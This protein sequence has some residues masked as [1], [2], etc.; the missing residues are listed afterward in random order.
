M[1]IIKHPE[2]LTAQ[3]AYFL[4]GWLTGVAFRINTISKHVEG[5]AVCGEL[6]KVVKDIEEMLNSYHPVDIKQK[7]VDSAGC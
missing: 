4:F 6:D 2:K 1:D 7:K 3:D 5:V